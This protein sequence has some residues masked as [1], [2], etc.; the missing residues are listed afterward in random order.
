MCASLCVTNALSSLLMSQTLPASQM[1]AMSLPAPL[2]REAW[3][4]RHSKQIRHVLTVTGPGPER[5]PLARL[6]R[7]RVDGSKQGALK[8]H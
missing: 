8:A 6:H 1:Q 2:H 3:H 4:P 7:Y 5:C